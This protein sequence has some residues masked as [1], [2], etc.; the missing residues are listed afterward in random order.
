MRSCNRPGVCG[1]V[2]PCAVAVVTPS[3]AT[4]AHVLAGGMTPAGPGVV[5]LMVCGSV[6]GAVAALAPSNRARVVLLPALLA[7]GQGLAHGVL[8]VSPT[9]P[10]HPAGMTHGGTT[11]TMLA[12]HALAVVAAAALIAAAECAVP[13]GRL[14]LDRLRVSIPVP[15]TVPRAATV[16]V[17]PVR[18]GMHA[19][20]FL[21]TVARR[22][23]PVP[24]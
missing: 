1:P 11:G 10:M 21:T 19:P 8:S 2:L 22:G 18:A 7:A 24:A 17:A 16:L 5:L 20:M 9:G 4:A 14:V 6:L 23:P 15:G 13:A 3:L 12:A